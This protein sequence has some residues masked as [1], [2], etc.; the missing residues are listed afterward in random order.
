[1]TRPRTGVL[2]AVLVGLLIGVELWASFFLP[3]GDT[4]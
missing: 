3:L 4:P 1:M 2:V